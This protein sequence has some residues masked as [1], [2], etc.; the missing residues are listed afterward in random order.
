MD[1]F[2]WFMATSCTSREMYEACLAERVELGMTHAGGVPG[3]A[4]LRAQAGEERRG[5]DETWVWTRNKATR[6]SERV[7]SDNYGSTVISERDITQVVAAR[8]KMVDGVVA[9]FEW[10]VGE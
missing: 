9:S 10:V 6:K 1:P 5:E 7:Y 2:D 3:D 8:A 4:R